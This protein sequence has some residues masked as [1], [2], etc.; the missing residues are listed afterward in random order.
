[1]FHKG[2]VQQDDLLG[3]LFYL[4]DQFSV[5]KLVV[6]TAAAVRAGEYHDLS[7]EVGRMHCLE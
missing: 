6:L 7:Y 4:V 2:I 3:A 1:M 5:W